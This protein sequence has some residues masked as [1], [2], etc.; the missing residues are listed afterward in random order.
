MN[1]CHFPI[2]PLHARASPNS[3][4]ATATSRAW[5]SSS[6]QRACTNLSIGNF[7]LLETS[8]STTSS[9]TSARKLL[10]IVSFQSFLHSVIQATLGLR[11]L[12]RSTVAASFISSP[13]L[14]IEETGHYSSLQ[15]IPHPLN[16]CDR[17]TS[18][19]RGLS[20]KI[21]S[22]DSQR[23]ENTQTH[24]YKHTVAYMKFKL[25]LLQIKCHV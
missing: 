17:T 23:S 21:I 14:K 5:S 8:L 12:L 3:G 25:K 24:T 6:P 11:L 10:V 19:M 13:I 16:H 20:P 2:V 18:E 22:E 15:Q 7:L 9:I 1:I 4:T